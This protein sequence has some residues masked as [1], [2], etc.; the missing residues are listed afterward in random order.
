MSFLSCDLYVRLPHLCISLRALNLVLGV[1]NMFTTVTVQQIEG[2]QN[3]N[4]KEFAEYDP[5]PFFSDLISN[6]ENELCE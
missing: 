5:L 6:L 3:K 1:L 2:D 4:S